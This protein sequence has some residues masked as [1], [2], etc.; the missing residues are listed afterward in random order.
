MCGAPAPHARPKFMAVAK[1]GPIP[2]SAE[3]RGHWFR[4]THTTWP[5]RSASPSSSPA[6]ARSMSS[7]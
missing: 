3:P 6:C 2:V 5:L 4:D 7:S 1:D